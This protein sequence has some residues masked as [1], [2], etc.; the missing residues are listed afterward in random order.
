MLSVLTK[1]LQNSKQAKKKTTSPDWYGFLGC[2]L[3]H[4]AKGHQLDSRSG[5]MTGLWTQSLVGACERQPV[6]VSLTHQC[7][8]PSLSPSPLLS[9]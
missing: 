4:K 5:C 3:S 1:H 9:K 6:D 8:T 7:F 2:V